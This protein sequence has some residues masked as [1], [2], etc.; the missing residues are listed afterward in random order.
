MIRSLFIF[1]SL[2]VLYRNE[3]SGQPALYNFAVRENLMKNQQIAIIAVDKRD[4]PDQSVNGTFHFR[5]N[6]FA[7]ELEFHEGI[8]VVKE[9]IERSTFIYLNYDGPGENLSK[10]YFVRV[11]DGDLSP[12]SISWIALLLVP[13]LLILVAV[14]FRKLIL[15]AIILLA[16]LFYFNSSH[17]LDLPTFFRTVTDGISSVF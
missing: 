1:L 7:R 4:V 15:Y 2:I 16:I 9:R 5:V 3:A 12:V 11:S 6:G 8:A 13:A 17:G 14:M 10:L